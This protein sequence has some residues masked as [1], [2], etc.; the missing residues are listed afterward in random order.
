MLRKKHKINEFKIPRFLSSPTMKH[1]MN[2][3]NNILK[4]NFR[5]YSN[6]NLTDQEGLDKAYNLSPNGVYIDGNKMYIA[7]TRWIK[8][9]SMDGP[10]TI[11]D[12]LLNAFVYQNDTDTELPHLTLQDA[13]DDLKIPVF[14][15]Q[16]SQRYQ[17]AAKELAKNPQVDTIVSHSLGGA[18]ALQLNKDNNN[19]FK[20]TTYGAP[21]F[22]I[23][24]RSGNRFRHPG[25]PVSMFD[26]GAVNVPLGGINVNPLAAH[27]YDGYN[28]QRS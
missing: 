7:G 26:M 23:G 8:N 5:R 3:N 14:K 18:V 27:A 24:G 15:T 25:D 11:E 6:N 22:Q 21:V 4:Q 9:A 16:Y 20:T 17:D 19:K 10:P 12:A 2:Q 28:F 1:I 13:W